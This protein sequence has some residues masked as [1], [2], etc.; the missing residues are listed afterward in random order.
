MI[1]RIMQACSSAVATA[2]VGA[3][4]MLTA[5]ARDE[6]PWG[7]QPPEISAW[8]RS[9]TQPDN[10]RVSCCSLADAYEAGSFEI[11]GDHYVAIITDGRADPA[12]NKPAIPNGMR[13]PVPNHKMK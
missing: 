4:L 9:L 11:E 7:D 10:P 1:G 13:I 2:V 3:V 5:L 12:H 8:F 6:V